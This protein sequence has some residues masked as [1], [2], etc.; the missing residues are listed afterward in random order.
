M[1]SYMFVARQRSQWSSGELVSVKVGVQGSPMGMS[2]VEVQ[3][4]SS[5]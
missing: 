3:K 5:A 2:L 1:V 4:R